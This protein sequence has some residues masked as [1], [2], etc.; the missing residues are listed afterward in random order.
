MRRDELIAADRKH[1]QSC[2]RTLQFKRRRRAPLDRDAKGPPER[3]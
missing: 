2:K 3:K 1:C